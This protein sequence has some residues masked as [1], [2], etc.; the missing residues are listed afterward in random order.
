MASQLFYACI[1]LFLAQAFANM[2]NF[3]FDYCGNKIGCIKFDTAC[4][5]KT[6]CKGIAMYYYNS[7]DMKMHFYLSTNQK[8]MGFGQKIG[9]TVDKMNGIKGVYCSNPSATTVAFFGATEA[10]APPSITKTSSQVKDVT[11]VDLTSNGGVTSCYYTRKMNIVD[12]DSIMVQ[13]NLTSSL[14]N[15]I[16]YG[17]VGTN[18]KGEAVTKHTGRTFVPAVNWMHFAIPKQATDAAVVTGS[19]TLLLSFAFV[20]V[21]AV[22]FY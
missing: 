19:S 5:N 22:G 21:A 10:E 7:T 18:V 3:K 8:W 4:T 9:G 1:V 16:A 6:N 14:L 11:V 2:A 15:A 13:H 17:D 20:L 12:A